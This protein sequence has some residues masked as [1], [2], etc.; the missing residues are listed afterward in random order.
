[1]RQWLV[2]N[3]WLVATLA[4]AIT[5]CNCGGDPQFADPLKGASDRVA[6]QLCDQLRPVA[7]ALAKAMG[8]IDLDGAD[9]A[10]AGYDDLS[11]EAD[12][13][14]MRRFASAAEYAASSAR[15]LVQN[16]RDVIAGRHVAAADVG[17]KVLRLRLAETTL[18]LACADHGHPSFGPTIEQL[19]TSTTR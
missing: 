2:R 6:G 19:T 13:V 4:M 5:L 1:M 17:P 7:D 18:H 16:N 14:G 11:T 15:A 9:A 12:R 10:A 8:S 3:R